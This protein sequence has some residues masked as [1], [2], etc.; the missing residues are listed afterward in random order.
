M[1]LLYIP[2]FDGTYEYLFN[3]IKYV[4]EYEYLSRQIIARVLEID[5]AIKR[6]QLKLHK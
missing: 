4:N 3:K 5:V 2:P 6:I 1:H